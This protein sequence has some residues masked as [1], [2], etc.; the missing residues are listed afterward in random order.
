MGKAKDN[1]EQKGNSGS[2]DT[3]EGWAPYGHNFSQGLCL[4]ASKSH[5]VLS[6]LTTLSGY[7]NLPEPLATPS[8][9]HTFLCSENSY[10]ECLEVYSEK[11]SPDS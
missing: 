1:G 10:L 7:S 8:P 3:I 2:E 9:T 11:T 5:G 4:L 6:F